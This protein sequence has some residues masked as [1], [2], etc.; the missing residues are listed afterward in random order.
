MTLIVENDGTSA[1]T[2]RSSLGP[3]STVLGSLDAVERHLREHE[4][5]HVVVVGPGISTESALALAERLRVSRPHVGVVL[6]RSR[7][8]AKLLSDALRAGIREVVNARELAAINAAARHA[9]ELA[10]RMLSVSG[11][12]DEGEEHGRATIITVFSAKGG[13]GKTTLSTNLGAALADGGRREVCIVDL[14]LAFGDVAIAMQLFPTHTISDA[15]SLEDTLDPSGVASLLTQH[16]PGLR[17]LS[18]P[19][20][21]GLA[22]NI[23]VS[24]VTRLLSIMRDMF[25]YV[26]VD[27][28]PA[29][30]DQVLAAFDASDLA[31]LLATLDIPALKNL[32][33]SLETLELL[34]YPK[35]KIRL[36]LNRAD[37]KVGL[38]AGEV[39]KTLRAPISALIPSSRAVPAATNR[40]VAI[41]TDQP[42][43]PVTL[44]IVGFV[45]QHITPLS[46]A[47][48]IP[49]QLRADRRGGLLRRRA[50]QT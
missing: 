32:K 17:V 41:V 15:V 25:D 4:H 3:E 40:G 12:D 2:L 9:Q 10:G 13:C 16:S 11:D 26:I 18:A 33:L 39:E 14:D 28:P 7:V 29:F 20:E 38:D 48:A 31:V 34:N 21:P 44:A 8:D 43:H 30:T 23:P 5:E 45:E 42:H 47:S 6:V 35:D 49:P 24:L 1:A 19:V 27:T 46:N 22:E 50:R 37:S 36:I